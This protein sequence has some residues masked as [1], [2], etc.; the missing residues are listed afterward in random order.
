MMR[1]SLNRLTVA[2]VALLALVATGCSGGAAEGGGGGEQAAGS[3]ASVDV[4]LTEFSIAPSTLDVP[5]GQAINF[6]VTNHGTVPH[7][8]AV[9][10]DGKTYDT[11]QIQGGVSATLAVPSLAAGTYSA[12]CS[13]PGHKD[14]GMTASVVASDTEATAGAD[15]SSDMG[16]MSSSSMSAQQMAEMHKAG[17][18]AF[19][20]G[21]E[22]TT[23]GGQPL[24][25][26]MDGRVK[27]FNLTVSQV[28]WEV[29]KGV[30]KDAMA[31]NGV[32]PG[33]EIHVSYG[34]HVRFVVQN[35][36][37]QPF[38]LHFHGMTVPNAMDG[39]PYVT[40][41]PIMPGQYWSYEFTVKDPP[42][43][44]VYHS[45]FNSTEQV[46][47]GLYG[48]IIIDPQGGQW[49]YPAAD[50]N[51][52]TGSLSYGASPGIDDSYTMFLGDGP[53]GYV[54]NGKSFPATAP[55]VAKTG[56]WVLLHLANDG[57]LLHPM[58]LHGYHFE[59]VS[60]DGF[61]LR[62]PYMAD[63]LVIAPGQRYDVLIHAIYPGAWAFHCHI[64]PH[65][66]GPQGM[67]GMVTALV[68]Q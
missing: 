26:T 1:R 45:H 11:G 9:D 30:F 55:L 42:G 31:F 23:Q 34:D 39:V 44:Y 16:S 49:P 13:I 41:D 12:Y 20:A 18:D 65:V 7:T 62:D 24:K 19:L 40:Q 54:L 63:T 61:P 27:V 58:H 8:F 22:T 33:P 15:A 51:P 4:S 59:V 37:D 3:P 17:V 57:S 50:V 14:L 6:N 48:A 28:K 56:D 32:V 66:E 53:L 38:V 60:Q 43:M 5:I 46:G 2:L 21:K 47:S 35:Q 10:V 36:M 67:Y 25:P 52:R 68:V 64:L 29:S